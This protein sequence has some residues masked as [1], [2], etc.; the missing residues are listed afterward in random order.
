MTCTP[1]GRAFGNASQYISR[2]GTLISRGDNLHRRSSTL[3]QVAGG[4]GGNLVYMDEYMYM[5]QCGII[6]NCLI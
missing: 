6:Q 5:I 2:G 1:T 3:K 4:R